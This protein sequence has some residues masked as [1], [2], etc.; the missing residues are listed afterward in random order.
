MPRKVDVWQ[1]TEP[2]EGCLICPHCNGWGG[3]DKTICYGFGAEE[4]WEKCFTCSG[5]GEVSKAFAEH[6]LRMN[7]T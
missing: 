4:D 3:R 6:V 5:S 1:L 2:S 7:S